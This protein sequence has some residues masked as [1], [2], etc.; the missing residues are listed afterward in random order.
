MSDVTTTSSEPDAALMAN[1]FLMVAA[2]ISRDFSI[3]LYEVSGALVDAYVALRQAEVERNQTVA[4]KADH[5]GSE[6]KG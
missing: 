4:P 1:G 3:P 5:D 2:E 6:P